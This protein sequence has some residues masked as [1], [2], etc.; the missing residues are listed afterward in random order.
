MSA[1]QDDKKRIKAAQMSLTR[2]EILM[3][4]DLTWPENALRAYQE[5]SELAHTLAMIGAERHADDR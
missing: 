2:L 1:E 3:K 5:A 4:A